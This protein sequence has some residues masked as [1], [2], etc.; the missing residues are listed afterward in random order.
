MLASA[1]RSLQV[2]SAAAAIAV[3]APAA[4]PAAAGTVHSF[5][6]VAQRSGV[7]VFDVRGLSGRSISR[8]YVTGTGRRIIVSTASVRR[9]LR[10][11]RLAIRV[12]KTSRTLA[13]KSARKAPKL[14]VETGSTTPTS[15]PTTSEPVATATPAPTA[16]PSTTTTTA[17][18][19][20][21]TTDTA[22]TTT[23]DTATTTTTTTTDLSCTLGGFGGGLVPG[24]CW[25]PYSDT[26]PF[27]RAIPASAPSLA[28]SAAIV[29]RLTGWGTPSHIAAGTA[30]SSDDWAHPTYYA[31]STD[32]VF[33]LHCTE[34]WGAC[35]IEGAQVRIP[36]AAKP[37][38]GGDAH[39]TVIDQVG[40]WEYDMW[41]VSSKPA[42]GGVLTFAWG[43]KT[44]IDG[45]GLGSDATAA[46]YGNAAGIIRAQELAAGEIR[47]A[48][49]MTINC[50]SGAPVYPALKSGRSCASIGQTNTDA[51]PMG[52]RFQLTM[53]DAQI[54]ALAVPAWKKTILRAMAHYGMY[55]G[56][57]GGG[58]WGVQAESGQTYTSFGKE[59]AL[60]SY[61]KS[62]GVPLYNGRY[63]FNI[64][65]GVDWARYLRVVDPCAAKGTC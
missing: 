15:T 42:G 11:G 7:V 53:T 22:V 9:A 50:D 31:R 26:S 35:A 23:T 27:N 49:F 12:P 62:V 39:M 64:R 48:L 40:G 54:D 17:S 16:E 21:T 65:D 2:A 37:A 45:D 1:R 38:A 44:R 60:V 32:P 46:R 10:S 8:A 41:K 52:A 47:H 3:L 51:P 57:T 55:T 28:N 59:D 14:V 6:P 5:A 29:T 24:A 25:R 33:T 43:G 19:V 30:G 20:T 34:A 61:G 63:I 36:D 58:A 18:P 4:A 13:R 56:D